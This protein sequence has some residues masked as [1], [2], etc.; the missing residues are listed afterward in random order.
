M[1]RPRL[2]T[3]SKGRAWQISWPQAGGVCDDILDFKLDYLSF[4]ISGWTSMRMVRTMSLSRQWKVEFLH[5]VILHWIFASAFHRNV[6]SR[7]EN[8]SS[9]RPQHARC[10]PRRKE[11]VWLPLESA[12]TNLKKRLDEENTDLFLSKDIVPQTRVWIVL[13][14]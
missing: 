5:V 4:T 8:L 9:P 14:F 12:N 2:T 10:P 6:S 1:W 11:A 3:A 7:K 13:L